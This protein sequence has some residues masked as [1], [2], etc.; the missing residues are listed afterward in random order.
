M[1]EF[2]YP[3]GHHFVPFGKHDINDNIN[4]PKVFDIHFHFYLVNHRDKALFG[5]LREEYFE[6]NYPFK[7]IVDFQ[8]INGTKHLVI[9]YLNSLLVDIGDRLMKLF[10]RRVQVQIS[11]CGNNLVFFY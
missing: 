8:R 10:M 7:L 5:I 4:K 3:Y 2:F 6:R 1:N 11:Q 9:V